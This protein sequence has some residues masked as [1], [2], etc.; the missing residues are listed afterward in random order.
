MGAGAHGERRRGPARR[1][2]APED[3]HHQEA[4]FIEADQ[5]SALAR[6]FF[7]PGASPAESSRARDDRRA[8]SPGAGDAAG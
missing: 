4:R 5:V 8:P 3:R 6:E 7:L 1:P 2:G